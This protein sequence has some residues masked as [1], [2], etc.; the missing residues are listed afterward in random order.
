MT[1][2][3]KRSRDQIDRLCNM[4]CFCRY[5]ILDYAV[6]LCH[7]LDHIQRRQL[8]YLSRARVARLGIELLIIGT[9]PVCLIH[10]CYPVV[11]LAV[12][13][14]NG[15]MSAAMIVDEDLNL[16]STDDRNIYLVKNNGLQ[17]QINCYGTQISQLEAHIIQN[18]P[19][20]LWKSDDAVMAYAGAIDGAYRLS[21]EMLFLKCFM[22]FTGNNIL[23]TVFCG[24]RGIR[25][26]PLSVMNLENLCLTLHVV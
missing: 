23:K 9:N 2:R 3:C 6:F 11:D 21:G 10:N 14:L 16:Y 24:I 18:Q 5:G 26:R 12:L 22:I 1:A 7:E 8:V 17:S 13:K 20:L 25:V 15:R 19:T 4:L